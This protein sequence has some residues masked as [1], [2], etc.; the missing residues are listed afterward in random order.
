MT[1]SLLLHIGYPKTATSWLQDKM[2]AVHPQIAMPWPTAGNRVIEE[3]AWKREADFDPQAVREAFEEDAAVAR[4]EGKS[5]VLS[6][7]ALVGDPTRGLYWGDA[8]IAR[9]AAVFPEAHVL[10][11]V[12]EQCRLVYSSWC[13]YVRRGGVLS[14]GQYVLR[15][16]YDE[17]GYRPFL[18]FEYLDF[19][20]TAALCAARFKGRVTLLPLEMLAKDPTAYGEAVLSPLGIEAMP[21][22]G[23]RPH[24]PSPPR[25]ALEFQRAL[26]RLVTMDASQG[27]APL[28]ARKASGRV[29]RLVNR[30][31]LDDRRQ[32]AIAELK[33]RLAPRLAPINRRLQDYTSCALDE[34]GYAL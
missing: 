14:L 32:E 31:G 2:F 11:S 23:A 24:Y 19:A 34:L 12:R 9:L 29:L 26:N 27:L 7:E 3:I 16:G 6:H 5:L 28:L 21:F 15:K 13:E 10:I 20:A 1:A 25:Q 33:A 4:A 30:L 22:G 18:P 17:A 8:V